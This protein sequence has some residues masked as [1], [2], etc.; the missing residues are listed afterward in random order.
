MRIMERLEDRQPGPIPTPELARHF[1]AIEDSNHRV[2][3]WLADDRLEELVMLCD[4]IASHST[5]A[6]EAAW[7]RDQTLL[8]MHLQHARESLKLAL[9]TFGLLPDRGR[10]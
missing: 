1:R 9:K 7:R 4:I 6:R 3:E 10:T 5:S 8:G 2:Q